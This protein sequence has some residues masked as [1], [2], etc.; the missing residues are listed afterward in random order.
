MTD[1]KQSRGSPD[2]KRIDIHDKDELR[3][4]TKSLNVFEAELKSAAG[5]AGKGA[6]ICPPAC[7]DGLSEH[8]MRCRLRESDL[9]DLH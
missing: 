6:S 7:G 5:L 1:D 9:S 2:N 3:N 4:W 8:L